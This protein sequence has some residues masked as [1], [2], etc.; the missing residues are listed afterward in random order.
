[1]R[2]YSSMQKMQSSDMSRIATSS[3]LIITDAPA[4]SLNQTA[5]VWHWFLVAHGCF[6]VVVSTSRATF[7]V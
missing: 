7:R 5:C 2:F 1:M 3:T 6:H 4:L